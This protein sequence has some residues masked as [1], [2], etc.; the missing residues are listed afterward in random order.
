MRAK[1]YGVL[2]AVWLALWGLLQISNLKIEFANPV[3]GF[4]AIAVAILIFADR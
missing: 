1:L 2:L 3:L 4:L